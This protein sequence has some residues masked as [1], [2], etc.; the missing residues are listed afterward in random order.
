VDAARSRHYYTV[1]TSGGAIL[2]LVRER[3]KDG[4]C[5][6]ISR[7]LQAPPAAETP[8]Q[9]RGVVGVGRP[10]PQL[11]PLYRVLDYQD[12]MSP[13][14]TLLLESGGEQPSHLLRGSA[15]L[16]RHVAAY[17]R[18][19]V[20]MVEVGEPL[21]GGPEG[22]AEVRCLCVLPAFR[23]MGIGLGLLKRAE[24]SARGAGFKSLQAAVPVTDES[25]AGLALMRSNRM[26]FERCVLVVKRGEQVTPVSP[27]AYW[28][29]FP[30]SEHS[31]V[32]AF[33]VYFKEL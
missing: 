3:L 19:M 11:P 33:A 5:W 29:S 31:I 2:E 1:R 17:E 9:P 26:E 15:P 20:G 13:W 28:E 23:R 7:S 30:G 6:S 32:V 10:K 12:N 4:E 8:E 16:A 14:M 24:A 27:A 25:G 21:L 22:R 18:L